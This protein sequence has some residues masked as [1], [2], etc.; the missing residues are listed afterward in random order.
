LAGI[1]RAPEDFI[2][3][4]IPL[5]RP[6]GEGQHTFV[7]V[8]KRLR[9][10][11]AVR[12]ELARF[13]GVRPAEVG[14]AGR[15]DRVAIARQWFSVPGLD[16]SR[17]LALENDGIRVLEAVRHPHKLRTGQLRGNR[18][19]L[20][21]REFSEPGRVAAALGEMLARGM[22]NRFGAQRFGS[23][24]ANAAR[25]RALLDGKEVAAS[26]NQAR[27]LLSA[28][29]AE[30]FNAVLA[31]RPL[32]H[33]RVETGDVAWLHASGACFLVEA[34]EQEA[35]RAA[36]FEISATGPLFG[37]RTLEPRGVPQE[38]ER[39][40]YERLAPCAAQPLRLPRGI[41]LRGAR[42]PLRVR[43][44]AARLDFLGKGVARLCFTLPPGSYAT[45]LVE[46]LLGVESARLG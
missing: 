26:R 33:D 27:F 25:A 39:V 5:F 46:E 35:P 40:V 6:T 21:L 37:S 16:P 9:N 13:A 38:R 43:P 2:V 19:E 45:V 29:Q 20:T 42:R 10:S 12:L 24:G 31:A 17:A 15:K 7:C 8:E 14:Y 11:E 32:P 1:G 3:D 4:E 28:L 36:A 30:V 18:F 23:D 44:E 41:R 22:S 34:A